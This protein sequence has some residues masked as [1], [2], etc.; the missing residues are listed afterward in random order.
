MK[1]I[2]ALNLLLPLE[3]KQDQPRRERNMLGETILVV[4]DEAIVAKD[5]QETLQ[6]L[7]YSVPVIAASGEEA[8]KEAQRIKPDLVLMDIVLGG[9]VD[10]ISAADSILVGYDIPVVYITAHADDNTVERARKTHPFGYIVKPFTQQQLNSSIK[11]ALTQWVERQELKTQIE[12]LAQQIA[13]AIESFYSF[14]EKKNE[15]IAQHSK[16]V[17]SLA[18]SIVAEMGYPK[19]MVDELYIAGIFHDI[20]KLILP[21]EI[22]NR[23]Y[24][25][26]AIEMEMFKRHPHL[27]AAIL[28]KMTRFAG[29]IT[30]VLQHHERL[31]GSGY[32]SGVSGD[33]IVVEARILAVADTVEMLCREAWVAPALGIDRALEEISKN[34]GRLYDPDVVDAC[35][36]LFNSARFE[37]KSV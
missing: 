11:V 34:K 20:G 31:D 26:N 16:G 36:N 9:E 27:G 37:F 12:K 21:M 32:P 19:A 13:E 17:S 35:L 14:M 3:L 24:N 7:G 29:I 33:D 22:V 6:G 30:P 23:P 1:E 15:R 28:G 25:L 8:V 2:K 10:G 5:I 18:V 4:E